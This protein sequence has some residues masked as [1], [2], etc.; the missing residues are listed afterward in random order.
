MRN[1]TLLKAAVAF[2]VISGLT[3]CMHEIG[4]TEVG[5]KT[6]KLFA[7]G[8]QDDQDD[9]GEPGATKFYIPFLTQ[10]NNFETKL[11]TLEMTASTTSGDRRTRDDMRFKT[12]DGNDISLDV[13]I[14][15]FIDRSKAGMI[16]QRVATTDSELKEQIVRTIARSKPRDIFGELETEGFYDAVERAAKAEEAKTRLNLILEPYGVTV[17]RV[18]TG[19]YRFNPAY[20]DAIEQKKIADQQVEKNK[21]AAKAATEEYLKKVEEAKGTVAETVA[22]ADG[23]FKVAKIQA[24]AYYEKQMRTA[25]AIEAEGRARA[26]G[27]MKMNEALSGAGGEAMVKLKIAESLKGKKIIMLPI[28]G[29]GIDL[30]TTDINSL[31]QMYG[32]QAIANK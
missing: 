16:L 21:S 3:G 32:I 13:T 30:R 31:L 29:G 7:K 25:Q 10:W 11:Q 12:I 24:D 26:E 22:R 5:V 1:N 15:Y 4:P 9:L 17:D 20:Q 23:A 8:V 27:I 2:L 14:T 6:N 18:N 19:D 28:G